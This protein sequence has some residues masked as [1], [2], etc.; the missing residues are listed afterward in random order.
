MTSSKQIFAN[1]T[2]ALKSTGPRTPQGKAIVSRNSLKHGLR[3]RQVLLP[4]ESVSRWE[5]F[6]RQ[7]FHQLAPL[8]ELESFLAERVIVAAWRLHRL[9]R[10]ESE[11]MLDDL[12]R[13]APNKW[14]REILFPGPDHPQ[15]LGAAVARNLR[16]PDSYSKL[17][18]YE[19][20]LE[21]SL[22]KNLDLLH[23]LQS[24]RSDQT[25]M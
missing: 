9:V 18:R 22:Y 24:T 10:I 23:R 20:T 11:V 13:L 21:R 15:T 3:S 12:H 17:R 1:R 2:N 4:D 14:Q 5:Q 19:A 6:H 8:G 7:L 25:P 16:G